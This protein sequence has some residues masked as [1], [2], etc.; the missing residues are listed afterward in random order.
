MKEN[1]EL[2]SDENVLKSNFDLNWEF[3]DSNLNTSFKVYEDLSR[4]YHDRYQFI[5]PEYSFQKNINIS[6]DYNG[7]FVFDT[8]GYN[9]NYNTNLNDSVII[10]NFHFKSNDKISLNGI[11]TSYDILLKNSN[12]YSD[13]TE[14]FQK[15]SSYELCK[16]LCSI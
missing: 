6:D 3:V 7:S 13:N 5:F 2:I 14:T 16:F 8:Y 15:N 1:S 11:V 4:G 10:N 9:K 12:S